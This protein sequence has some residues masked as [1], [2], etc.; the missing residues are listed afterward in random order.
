MLRCFGRPRTDKHPHSG[1]CFNYAH[2]VHSALAT[3]ALASA[4]AVAT[5]IFLTMVEP[6]DCVGER[7]E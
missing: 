1:N 6:S 4:R 5:V 3:V 2:Y 7:G